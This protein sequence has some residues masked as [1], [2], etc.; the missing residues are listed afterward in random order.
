MGEPRK[1]RKLLEAHERLQHAR[2]AGDGPF[3][4]GFLRDS[5]LSHPDDPRPQERLDEL[6]IRYVEPTLGGHADNVMAVAWTPGGELFVTGSLDGR[7]KVWDGQTGTELWTAVALST[8]VNAVAVSPSG[9]VLAA[10]SG[11]GEVTE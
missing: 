5:L 10:G 3:A 8:T 4:V 9:A 6:G 2:S 11:A 1:Y 7:V